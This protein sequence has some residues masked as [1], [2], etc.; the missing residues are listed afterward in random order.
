MC[1]RDRDFYGKIYFK[2]V[3]AYPQNRIGNRQ[4]GL[5]KFNSLSKEDA[6]LAAVNLKRYLAVAGGYVKS[7]Q[8]YIAEGCFTEDWL[9]AEE[10]T[11]VKKASITTKPNTKTFTQDYDNI[12]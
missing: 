12:S 9:K 11:K 6:K 5:K 4:H 2:I 1:I 8:N 10:Q 7:L 3:D